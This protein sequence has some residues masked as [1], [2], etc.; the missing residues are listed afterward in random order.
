M[1][2]ESNRYLEGILTIKE[3]SRMVTVA[4]IIVVSLG[5][6]LDY[7]AYRSVSADKIV[8]NNR[9]RLAKY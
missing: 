5:L 9:T 7:L 2:S 8:L 6:F 3:L 4:A 1:I